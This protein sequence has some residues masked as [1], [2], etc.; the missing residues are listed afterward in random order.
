[1][2]S[3]PCCSF[4]RAPKSKVKRLVEGCGNGKDTVRICG[5][6]VRLAQ[7]PLAT[8]AYCRSCGTKNGKH[9]PDCAERDIA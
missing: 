5:L 6:C 4:C 8:I 7:S 2:T 3:E 9:K 1:M